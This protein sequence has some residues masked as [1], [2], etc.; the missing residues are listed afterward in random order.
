M[1]HSDNPDFNPAERPDFRCRACGC[2]RYVPIEVKRRNGDWYRT[3][4]YKCCGC[5]AMFT[6]PLDFAG[7]R[8]YVPGNDVYRINA[9]RPGRKPMIHSA[10]NPY[11]TKSKRTS[12]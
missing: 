1:S 9:T 3:P 11:M 8:D 5:T 6:D 2:D 10:P 12:R 7:L 4:F